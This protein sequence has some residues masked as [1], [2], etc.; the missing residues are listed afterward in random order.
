VLGEAIACAAHALGD[1]MAGVLARLGGPIGAEARAAPPSTKVMRAQWSA[2]ARAPVPA[3]LRGI[4]A[5]WIE[6]GLDGVPAEA[7][8]AVAAGGAG[9]GAAVW[10]ARWACARLVPMPAIVDGPVRRLDDV[11]ALSGARLGAWL[12]EVGADQLAMALGAAGPEA[13]AS[14]IRVAGARLANAAVRIDEAPRRGALG[15]VRAAVERC[16]GIRLEA[17]A[18]LVIGARA[19]APHVARRALARERIML[20]LPRA[21][22]LVVA[23]ELAARAGDAVDR[24]PTWAALAVAS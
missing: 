7:R 20:R 13:L 22:G 16:R 2:A 14:G 1:D 10:L 21:L 8:A 15:P 4:D 23:A 5:S 24:A 9:D 17:G 11:L 6:A 19:I 12:D 18:T 3:G